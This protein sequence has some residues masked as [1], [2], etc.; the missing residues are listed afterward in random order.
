MKRIKKIKVSII[1]IVV[2]IIVLLGINALIKLNNK[3]VERLKKLYN[4]LNSSQTYLF[5][6]EYDENT[7]IIMAQKDG[8]TIIDQY[9]ENSHTTT[10]IKDN[11]TYLVLHDREE[12]YVYEQNNVEQSILTEGLKEIVDKEF[13]VDTE[14]I[15]GKKY[16]YEEYSGSTMFMLSN[17]LNISEEEIKTRF[18][19]DN[20]DNLV[21]VRTI[22]GVNQE[23]V[24]IKIE[25]EVDDSIFEIPSNYAEN[26]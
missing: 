13:I 3:G 8:K 18:Y 2:I 22:K 19:F 9:S 12:Y 24:K 1:A 6:M 20:D 23:L 15:N 25:K 11:N 14:K 21:Y 16:L 4:E 5:E 26:S 17:T 10:I 7:K